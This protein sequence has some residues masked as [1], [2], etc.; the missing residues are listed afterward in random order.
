MGALTVA[1]ACCNDK[2]GTREITEFL[3]HDP[4]RLAHILAQ[5]Q[6]PLKDAAAVNATRWLL[7][8]RLE[9]QDCLGNRQRGPHQ[10]QSYHTQ[11]AKGALD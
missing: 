5:L 3:K 2:K 1:C 6:R 4:E 8:E 10:V 7:Y 11:L 9:A